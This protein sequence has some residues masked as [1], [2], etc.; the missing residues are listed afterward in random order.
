MANNSL[1]N[2]LQWAWAQPRLCW[3]F[4]ALVPFSYLV[5]A[6]V[7]IRRYVYAAK[8]KSA[9]RAPVPVVVVGNLYVGG[10]GKTPLTLALVELL[11]QHGWQPGIVSRGY[12]AELQPQPIAVLPSSDARAV[13]DEPLLLAQRA[14]C[15]VYVHRRRALAAQALLAAYPDVNILLCD[16]G[17]QHYALARD[18]E[19]VVMDSRGMGNGYL[20]PAGPLREP[21]SRLQSIPVWACQASMPPAH[22]KQ[23]PQL[24]IAPFHLRSQGLKTM[25]TQQ[26]IA[27]TELRGQRVL[28][29]AGIGAPERFFSRMQAWLG[30][31]GAGEVMFHAFPDHHAYTAPELNALIEAHQ[32]AYVVATEKDAVKCALIVDQLSCTLKGPPLYLEVSAELASPTQTALLG[33]ISKSRS[34]LIS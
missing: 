12:K 23:P 15:P 28:V 25:R 13:G 5:A 3:P 11:K 10:T 22:L 2:R 14:G 4:V 34:N 19:I 9:W 21:V 16:D 30:E 17:L 6:V 29:F 1:L 33:L 24:V 27:W 8:L 7:A 26:A 31:A 20:L 18:L 32:A